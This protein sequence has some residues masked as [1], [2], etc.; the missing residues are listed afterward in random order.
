MKELL[1]EHDVPVP[2]GRMATSA[3]DAVA[4]VE[5]CGGKAVL[6]AVVPG[7]VHKS[8]A[9]GVLLGIEPGTA[10]S[11]YAQVSALGGE[12]W[13]EEMVPSGVEALVGFTTSALGT[14]LTVGVGGV[15]TEVVA[16]VSLRVLPVTRDDV[17]DM[18]DETRLG[19]LLGGVRGATAAD[20]RAFVDCVLRLSG[21][22]R[23]WPDGFELDLNPVTV[24]ADGVRVLDAAYVA[25]THSPDHL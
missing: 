18:V 5:E 12:V 21:M 17:E 7:L 4:A 15:L 23:D 1:A 6:K 10:A 8:D 13:V 9:G 3:D 19:M 11:A 14:V 22:V 2:G 24:L 20:R 25:P 16:D